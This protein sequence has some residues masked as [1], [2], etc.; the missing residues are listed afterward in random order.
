MNTD[1]WRRVQDLFAAALALEAADREEFLRRA[2]ADDE[3][4]LAEVRAL[5]AHDAGG[6]RTVDR[7]VGAAAD[8]LLGEHERGAQAGWIGRRL[9]AWRIAAH[10]ADGGMGAVFRAERAD[11]QYEQAAAVKLINPALLSAQTRARMSAERQIL[12][13]LNHPHIARLLDGGTTDDG[14]PYLV[15]EYV[16]GVPIDLFCN[17]HGLDTKARL[18]L[19]LK[20]CDAVDYAHRNLVVH[21]DIKPSNILVD[22]GGTP[23]LLDFGISKLLDAAGDAALTRADQR[24]LTPAHASPEQITGATITTATD[25]YAL[26]VLLYDLL[27][28]RLPFAAAG[29][30]S[31]QLAQAILQVD[32][33]RPS[34]AVGQGSSARL[35]AAQRR[36][37]ALTPAR[38][39]RELDG[40]LDTIVLTALRKEPERRYRSARALAEDIER[41]LHHEPVSA[42]PD[43][44]AYRAAKFI[45]RH[46]LGVAGSV[47]ALLSAAA[48]VSFY[49]W[50]LS[51]ERDRAR[52]AAERAEKVAA[53][54]AGVFSV[55]DPTLNLGKTV[56][57]RELL[58]NGARQIERELAGAPDVQ[59]ALM[60]AMGDAYRNLGLFAE[61]RTLQQK[62]LDMR[63][64]VFGVDSVEAAQSLARLGGVTGDLGRYDEAIEHLQRA[65]SILRRAQPPDG[66]AIARALR[67]LAFAQHQAGKDYAEAERTYLDAIEAA[68][69][70]GAAGD[71][72]R[73]RSMAGLGFVLRFT[74]KLAQARSWLE[75]ALALRI[76]T[77][78]DTHPETIE[79]INSL[80]G[81]LLRES[82]HVEAIAQL[83]RALP[84]A[85]TVYGDGH[86]R[87]AYIAANLGNA[88]VGAGRYADAERVMREALP[89]FRARLGEDHPRTSYMTENLANAIFYQ[90][91]YAEALPMYLQSLERIRQRFGDAHGEYGISLSN[92]CGV[93]VAMERFDDAI[94]TCRRADAVL[95]KAFGPG[96]YVAVTNLTKLGA[97]FIGVRRFDAAESALR[98][99]HERA[100]IELPPEHSA[101]A[102]IF[103]QRGWLMLAR[104]RP[105]EAEPLFREGLKI[106]VANQPQGGP[107]VAS[108]QAGLGVALTRL[109][110][111]EDAEALLLE[112]HATLVKSLGA[113]HGEVRKARKYLADLYGAWNRP[114]LAARYGGAGDRNPSH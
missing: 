62:V 64:A 78:G 33:P 34:S 111:F 92:V 89:V 19:F 55:A 8:A 94:D 31:A 87:T 24:L 50:Q 21:R 84:L 3:A 71:A 43:T 37:E 6:E 32:A 41:H 66:L 105:R 83:E 20:V 77:F 114:D 49:T 86:L 22:A 40:D 4:L 48:L 26:G 74:G 91:R 25:V 109:K 102:D 68:Q 46:R 113:E 61:A 59:A 11:G 82:R 45:R 1:R 60:E 97:A 2:C 35:A 73:A 10:L 85:R 58:D 100:Q 106:I 30:T 104:N 88:L 96:H 28:G 14:V 99:A 51:L 12:A 5:L 80:G 56:T 63:V 103:D 44:L 90:A 101:R 53:F 52:A 76:R 17:E 54:L 70:A 27:T 112:S 7:I 18:A 16:D 98:Q 93:Y 72:E 75:Q 36:G 9:G 65:L 79:S 108:K 23:K 110:R 95:Q 13:R 15:M 38:L 107:P 67:T 57:A 29:R 81:L 47:A 39:R 42:R 69:A